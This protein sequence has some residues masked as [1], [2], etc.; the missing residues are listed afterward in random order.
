MIKASQQ[1]LTDNHEHYFQHQRFAWRYARSCF[2]AGFM[3][4]IHGMI[5]ALFQTAASKKVN[6]LANRPRPKA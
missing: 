2:T 6:E 1:H 5:P 3:A 4:L